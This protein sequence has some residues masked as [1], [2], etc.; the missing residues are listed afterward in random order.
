MID[1]FVIIALVWALVL[2]IKRGFVAQLCHLIGLYIALLIAPSFASQVGSL[3]MDDPGKAYLAG[4]ILIVA[5]ALVIIWIVAPLVKAIVVWKPVKGVDALLG[6]LLNIT[7]TTL[8]IAALFSIFDRI[9][10][11]SNIKQEAL[12]E[13]VEN[14]TE[15]DIKAKILALSN[16]DIDSEMRHYFEHKYVDYETL[17]SSV[18]FYPLAKVGT[19][20]IPTIKHFDETIRTEAHRA[21]NEEIFFNQ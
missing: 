18:C 16:A 4:I 11:S 3:F 1:I 7:A 21:I 2:G 12:I 10:L 14:H 20:I 15:G 17:D 8:V 9:N 13:I 19:A 5:A 6:A